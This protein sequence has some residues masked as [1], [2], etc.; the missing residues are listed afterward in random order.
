MNKGKKKIKMAKR[1]KELNIYYFNAGSCN[2]CDIELV[3]GVL[4]NESKVKTNIVTDP[5]KADVAVFTGILT[6]KIKPHF[7]KVLKKLPP[8]A[9]KIVFGSCAISGNAFFESYTF[10]GPIDKY[11]KIDLYVNGCPPKADDSFEGILEKL[12]LYSSKKIKEEALEYWRG[13]LKFY[14]EKCIGCLV[15]VYHCPAR[16][17]KVSKANKKFELEYNFERCF[18]CGMCQRK[19]PAGAIVLTHDPKMVEKDKKNFQTKGKV[20]KGRIRAKIELDKI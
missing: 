2:G 16:T 12:G 7:L 11:A 18:F 4:L 6:K 5:K 15:C 1:S 13:K 20:T 8:R 19:C 10:A 3:A 17:I 14:P 9:K